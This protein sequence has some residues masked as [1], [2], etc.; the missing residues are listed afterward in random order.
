[1]TAQ[2]SLILAAETDSEAARDANDEVSRAASVA[3]PT[4]A[5][6][7]EWAARREAAVR[8][9]EV[10]HPAAN[11]RAAFGVRNEG[12]S[13]FLARARACHLRRERE[14]ELPALAEHKVAVERRVAA[15][16][17]GQQGVRLRL[18]QRVGKQACPEE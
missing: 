18:R 4:R 2:S 10:S 6:S 8:E 14:P 7:V 13:G 16:H 1:M 17:R 11:V 3:A 9:P 15:E 12:R 5:S